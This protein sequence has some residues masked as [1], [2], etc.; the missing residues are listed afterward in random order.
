MHADGVHADGGYAHVLDTLMVHA[1]GLDTLTVHADGWH[2]T[3]SH[4][5]EF[6]IPYKGMQVVWIPS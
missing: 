6:C 5:L 4:A 2:A 1:D 3:L